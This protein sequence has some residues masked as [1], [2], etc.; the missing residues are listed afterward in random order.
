MKVFPYLINACLASLTNLRKN[1][2]LALPVLGLFGV[3]ATG[4]AQTTSSWTGSSNSTWSTAG[5]WGGG[6]PSSTVSALFDGTFTNQP[7]LTTGN[8]TQGIWLT[9]GA[10][11]DVTIGASSAQTLALT[12]NA[13]LNGISNAGI[14]MND[15]TNNRNLTFGSNVTVQLANNT[16]F[17]NSQLSGALTFNGVF[18]INGNKALT[19]GS[20]NATGNVVF[21]GGINNLQ[22]STFIASGGNVTVN[23]ALGGTATTTGGF[24]LTAG[25][26]TM[27]L[28][29]TGHTFHIMSGT[30]NGNTGTL[31]IASANT[32]NGTGNFTFGDGT[33]LNTSGS[34]I[35]SGMTALFS[36]ANSNR[37]IFFG[38]AGDTSANNLT[39]TGAGASTVDFTGS[40]ITING[41]GVTISTNTTWTNANTSA[42]TFTVNGAG[43]TFVLAGLGLGATGVTA[44]QSQT[45]TGT[46]NLFITGAVTNG[47]SAFDQGITKNGTG[48]LTLAG[49]NTY[50]GTTT[51]TAGTLQIGNGSTTGSL[52][53]AS[54]ITNNAMLAFNR[55]NNMTQGTDFSSTI[56][57]T[58]GVIQA[59][60][61]TLIFSGSNTYTGATAINAGALNL[62]NASGL[63]TTAAGTTVASGA[64]LQLQGG[65]SVGAEAL[66]LSGTGVSS[67]G[68]LRN[69]SGT[70]SYGGAIT[71]NDAT[72]INSDA[73]LLTLSGNLGGTQNLTIGGAGNTTISGV[74][75]TSTGTLTKDGAG[76]LT[77]SGNNTYSGATTISGGNL[78][79]LG[80]NSLSNTAAVILANTGGV[81]LNIN[82][83]ETI[84]PLQGGGGIGGTVTIAASQTLR[85]NQSADQTFAGFI[86]GSGALT[87]N[88]SGVLTL[89]GSN[90]YTGATAINIG[91]LNLQNASA[92]GTTAA[93]TTVASGAALQLQGGI[94][95]GAESLTL[96]G[97]GVS[98]DG[99][100]RNIS[101]DNSYAGNITLNAATRI[102]SDAGLLTLSGNFSAAQN[103]TIG[104]AGNTTISGAIATSTGSVTKDGAGS[105]TLSGN[106]NSTGNI[107]ANAG[108]LTL[109]LTSTGNSFNIVSGT[110]NGSTGIVRIANANSLNGSGNFTFG[111]GTVLNTSGA[112]I[113]SGMRALFSAA[114]SNRDIFFGQAGDTS[115]NNITF[116]GAGASTVDFSGGIITINGSG[117]TISTN[118]TWTNAIA[119]ART[120]TVNGA[121]N[122][123]V[124]A[125]LGL[126]A[127]GD[128]TSRTQTFTGSGNL[129][130]S[131]A[132]TNGNA[133]S[134]Q[135]IIKTGNG[136]LTLAGSN[137]YTGATAINAG[138]LNLQ[139]ADGLGTAAAGTTVASGAA[140]QLQGGISVGG[141]A[142]TL[143]GN[144]VSSDGALRNISGTNSYGGAITLNAATRINSDAG[145]LTLSGNLSG[146]QNL[147]IG[148][149]GNTTISGVVGTS[150]GTLTKGG[151]GT[152][153]L[154]GN[155]TYSGLTTI[156]SGVLS[157]NSTAALGSTS[158]VNLAN[159]TALL[160]TGS[161]AT[162]DRNITVTSGTG[163]LQNTGS[164]LLTLSGALS[165]NG[166]T[167]TLAGGSNGITVSGVISGSNPNS[168]LVIDGGTTTLSNANNS[169]NGPTFIINSGTLNANSAGALP[170]S[171][172]TAVTING[173]ST[174]ALGASQSVASLS[175]TSGSTV[176][177]N[178]NTLTIN[179][180]ATTTYS[181]GIS[182]TG[183]LVK[184]GS[185]TQT[186][187]GATT[188][189]G[190]TTVNSGTLQAATANALANTSQVVLNNGGSF[191]VTA[192]NAVNDNAAINLNG[193]RIAVSGN[194]DETVG[195]LTLSANSTIDFSGFG[196]TLRFG[197]IG[198][199]APD[200]TLAIWNWS[201][202]PQYGP[203]VNDYT[204][205]SNLVFTDN[206][207]IN[208]KLANISFY[209]DSGSS[210]VGNG[211]EQG[212]S[213]GV[214]TE[215]IAVP[216]P[217]AFFYAVALLAGLVAQYLRRRARRKSLQ[218][219]HPEFATR[220]IAHQRDLLPG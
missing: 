25:T 31:R 206:S 61:G 220:A 165:K 119:S 38:Q 43:N 92:L 177:L 187:A 19:L 201:G 1:L 136:T 87:K 124:L 184:N 211:F 190:T 207:N 182:G 74:V 50:N 93:G 24:R 196:G 105:L 13:M 191:L 175:G 217:E 125:G 126:G 85:V 59:G 36:T 203:P 160:Y 66:T 9:S 123:F 18:N 151:V 45:I 216:E 167:L 32:L 212:F 81:G 129:F 140:L 69:I 155:N 142:L 192:E 70:N 101:G 118:T 111:D 158:G 213:P 141:E 205:P 20:A 44:T 154:S 5:N 106:I 172:L 164:G 97:T 104:G 15:T 103:L 35:T 150:A 148:G 204:N 77:L 8:T 138:V 198:S 72:R 40:I 144:G 78:T 149:A 153:T 200:A 48:T 53:V 12:G 52:A 57:G 26:L 6:L 94:S 128:A 157:I 112:A 60:S 47:N 115:A 65:I 22:T 89:S 173:S 208:S 199:W 197:G 130:I 76:T 159:A 131:G 95:V 134:D 56:S 16:G 17:Y 174:L 147:T 51:I 3:G 46:G 7:N 183:N 193:G 100:L 179:G 133:S 49:S 41:S 170:T 116:T 63:G 219:H 176:N 163:T 185:G 102:N 139:N 122:T 109:N 169:Y 55:S 132:V 37:D 120:L 214:G 117:V 90:T 62:Q 30:T 42:R 99:A 143:S 33:V 39:F 110:A 82:A 137:T 194:F 127:T 121:A 58:G 156:S 114:N 91:A 180:S 135:G 186:L 14:Y 152:L 161:D 162:L 67:D 86:A 189:N 98:S 181:G 188:F 21:N 171:T 79:L 73:G 107:S 71:L 80:G 218:N 146:A 2:S 88:G 84:G 96:S 75:G 11:Q 83:S 178:N 34:A 215:I 113:T 108:T 210:F 64:A 166:T 145:L 27:N 195:L 168:D 202:T 29:N 54:A 209:S 28:T 4:Y 68:A 23:G 10:S